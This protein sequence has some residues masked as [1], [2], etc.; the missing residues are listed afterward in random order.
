MLAGLLLFAFALRIEVITLYPYTIHPDEVFQVTE[1]AY[2]L[3][4][5]QGIVPWEFR[6][7]IRGWLWPGVVGGVI[8]LLKAITGS[9]AGI[10]LAVA[11]FCSLLSLATV[12]VGYF[13][14]KQISRTHA[15]IGG[16]VGAIWV[17]FIYFAAHPLTETIAADFLLVALYL[18]AL[19]ATGR[20]V[21]M[22]GLCLGACFIMRF[23]LG[24]GLALAAFWYARGNIVERWLPLMAGAAIPLAIYSTVDWFTWGAPFA[25][26]YNNFDANIV[27]AR[28]NTYGIEPA[29]AY[30]DHILLKWS[31]AFAV[32]SALIAL[33]ARRYPMWLAVALTIILTHSLIAHKEY[34]FIFPAIACLITLAAIGAG[35]AVAFVTSNV[36]SAHLANFALPGVLALFAVTSLAIAL[37]TEFLPLWS[38]GR[39]AIEAFGWAGKQADMCGMGLYGVAWLDTP[40]YSGLHRSVP[41]YQNDSS[42]P[43]AI[44]DLS[45]AYNFALGVPRTLLPP[46]FTPVKCFS[47][48]DTDKLCMYE[49]PGGCVETPGK[50]INQELVDHDE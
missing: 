2:R 40:G 27:H 36:R 39:P 33:G 47:T 37:S 13:L 45:H 48:N 26:I 24:P 1:Q 7:G 30:L 44:E 16:F 34:R 28:S 35:D 6:Q 4:Y 49:R 32:L 19:T 9:P 8:W 31:G 46:A 5:H 12:L 29:W 15:I 38:K 43:R 42:D 20:R 25:S 14:G 3:V 50:G 23:H 22:A 41:I 11:S 10:A 18:M 21:F 17:E